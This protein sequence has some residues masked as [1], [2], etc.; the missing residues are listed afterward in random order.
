MKIK[1]FNEM[2]M[3]KYDYTKIL[4]ILKKSYGWGMGIIESIDDFE[5]NEEYFLNPVDDNDYS[6]KFHIYLTDLQSGNL[7]GEFNKKY[8]IQLGKWKLSNKVQNPTSFYNK[9]T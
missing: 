4:K 3:E 6:E 7:R 5:N 2:Y 8:S 9:L 1:R